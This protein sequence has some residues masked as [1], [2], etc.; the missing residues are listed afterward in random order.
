MGYD[1]NGKSVYLAGPMRGHEDLNFPAFDEA[2]RK[3]Y[4]AGASF[5]F[6]PAR[7]WGHADKHASWYMLHDLHRLTESDGGRPLFDAIVM[8]DGWHVSEGASLEYQVARAC[9]IELVNLRE[10]VRGE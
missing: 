10:V 7:A 1:F 8:L 9:G 2:Q 4:D 6:N 3:L 5:V